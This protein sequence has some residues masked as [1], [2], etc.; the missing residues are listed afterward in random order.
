MIEHF[1]RV[2]AD[3]P[4]DLII[5][6]IKGLISAGK[7]KP[8]DRLPSESSLQQ[9]MGVKRT[10]IR[11]ALRRLEFFGVVR[12]KPQSGSYIENI[13]I[14]ALE[15]LITNILKIEKEDFASLID[16]R[17]TL[18]CRAVELVCRNASDE[19]IEAI[20]CSHDTFLSE[21]SAGKRGL[22]EDLIF[23]LKIAEF[24]RNSI[25]KTLITLITPDVLRLS[26]EATQMS[27][28]RLLQTVRE[29]AEILR[30][31]RK[32]DVAG[33]RDAMAKH[34]RATERMAK[35]L[36]LRKGG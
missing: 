14:K 17:T 33:A 2:T 35:T 7:L 18:E 1:M 16:T 12:T 3:S 10:H 4:V 20:A 8:G 30:R 5:D 21:V 23:H 36:A 22:E 19:E 9:K 15:G 32:R 25:L 28:R 27:R 31:I 6:Q 13:G 24:S 34:M 26:E 11:D 29:H